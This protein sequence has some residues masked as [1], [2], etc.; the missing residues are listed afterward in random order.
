L[1][2][3]SLF[4]L[5]LYFQEMVLSVWSILSSP[6]FYGWLVGLFLAWIVLSN[7]FR[8]VSL[9]KGKPYSTAH[10][11]VVLAPFLYLATYG[12]WMWLCDR[13][14]AA[15]FEH[16]KVFG[17]YGPSISLVIVMLAFQIWDL[18][19]T[20]AMALSNEVKNQMQH[21]VHHASTVL[22]VSLALLNG[23]H[24]FMMYY[25]AFFFG[26]SEISSL[27]LAVM[28]LF[29][30]SPELQEAYPNVNEAVKVSF[31]VLFLIIR[32]IYWPYVS[33][34]FWKTTLVSSAPLWLQLIW[35]FFNIALT[36]LQFYWGS[37]VVRGIAK[38][39]KGDKTVEARE[40]NE[41]LLAESSPRKCSAV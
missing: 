13:N 3:S 35:Y 10:Q 25:G 22:L 34:D 36:L 24:G 33:V 16:D 2:V 5:R 9:F 31:G 40:V 29:K 37:L 11:V 41:H 17:N 7:C 12:S 14:F 20:A 23:Q 18:F 27:P 4:Y 6:F 26:V 19:V 39:L 1:L 30:Y 32:C 21:I 28:D 8:G 38:I 15:A